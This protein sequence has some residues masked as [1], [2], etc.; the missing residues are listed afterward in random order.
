MYYRSHDIGFF[1]KVES[2]IRKYSPCGNILVS[3]DLNARCGQKTDF[4]E[5]S[6]RYSN[7]VS[8]VDNMN[9]AEQGVYREQRV[10]MD[11]ICNAS[12]VKLIDLC[13][14]SD[15]RIVNGRVGDDAAKLDM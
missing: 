5:P 4:T 15:L 8:T 7:F 1:E 10:S 9:E 12:G 2:D 13:Q 3:G 11:N 6:E 14:G